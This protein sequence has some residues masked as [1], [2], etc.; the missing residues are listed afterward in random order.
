MLSLIWW[1]WIGHFLCDFPLQGDFLA[2]GKNHTA[3][4]SGV[5]WFWCLLAHSAIHAGWVFLIT[6]SGVLSLLE[7]CVH[8]LLDY[9][10]S[11]GHFDFGTDQTLHLVC[12]LIWIVIFMHLM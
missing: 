7:L 12:K 9:N 5:P 3:P 8:A 10:K 6:G 1:L 11:A 2:R 4:L